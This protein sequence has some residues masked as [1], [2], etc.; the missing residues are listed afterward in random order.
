MEHVGDHLVRQVG[1]VRRCCPQGHVAVD[2]RRVAK[3]RPR[4]VAVAHHRH[5]LFVRVQAR[6]RK[7][8]RQLLHSDAIMLKSLN[9]AR[10]A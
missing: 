8:K 7:K 10:R 4:H 5:A 3:V 9:H 2:P 1:R 6:A